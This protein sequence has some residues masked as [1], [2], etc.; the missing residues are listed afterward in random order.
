MTESTGPPVM[1]RSPLLFRLVGKLP[2]T[3]VKAIGQAQWKHPRLRALYIRF[4]QRFKNRDLE[5]Q[6]GFGRG[7]W[8]NGGRA[9]AGYALGTSEPAVQDALA[10]LLQPGMTMYDVGANVGFLTILAGRFVGP[11]GHVIG[12]EPVPASA[13]QI[14]H[15][16]RLNAFTHVIVCEKALSD[17]DG[18]APFLV[19]GDPT[20][21]KLA[22]HDT[23]VD[24]QVGEISVTRCRLDTIVRD[25]DL[26]LPHLIKIDVEGYEIEVLAGASETLRRSRP[27]LLIELH[28]TNALVA[29]ALTNLGYHAIVLDGDRSIVEAPWYAHVVAA[30]MERGD[31]VRAVDTLHPSRSTS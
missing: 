23:T 16:A 20:W 18:T 13:R 19:S 21:S 30:P 6:M 7:L 2:Q 17:T 4:T 1:A 26:P 14:E 8:F 22:G 3:W 12:F 29:E 11:T 31:W 5:I 24:E 15:N 28:G 10:R 25:T 27:L 9:N